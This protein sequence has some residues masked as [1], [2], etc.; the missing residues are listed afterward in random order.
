[1]R[2]IFET[3][4][5][6]GIG[7]SVVAYLPQVVHLTKEHCSAGISVRAWSL[8]LASSVLVGALAVYRE[9][10]VFIGLA[11]SSLA[12]STAVLVLARKHRY[13]ACETHRHPIAEPV[14]R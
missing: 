9:D 3:L 10:F 2:P 7:L 5:I 4:G 1:M 8:W 6:I 12:S 11:A 13:M 14:P